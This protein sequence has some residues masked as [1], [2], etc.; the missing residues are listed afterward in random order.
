MAS[1]FARV[2]D[3]ELMVVLHP[4]IE[5]DAIDGSIER[6]QS[7]LQSFDATVNVV[8]RESP[9]GR[10]RLA[11]PVRH[12]GRDI[13]DGIYALYYFSSDASRLGE[14]E[15]E[16]KL[17]TQVLRYLL[18]LQVAPTMEPTPPAEEG[19]SETTAV[20]EAGGQPDGPAPA[21]APAAEPITETADAPA[22]EAPPADALSETPAETR[23]DAVAAAPTDT[24]MED[25]EGATGAPTTIPAGTNP[26]GA[27]AQAAAEPG[28]TPAVGG[29]ETSEADDSTE[30]A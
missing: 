17:N 10:R 30:N 2:R 3:Y 15:R 16:L 23:P 4:E 27:T 8:N 9:W 21:E 20:S 19:G 7:L 5:D 1:R 26:E 6:I 13:R 22:D 24:P 12:E 18:T 29:T 25:T 14:F 28:E 11:Y